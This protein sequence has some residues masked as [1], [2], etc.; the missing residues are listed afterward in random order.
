MAQAVLSYYPLPN[1]NLGVL[2]PSYNYQ[3][4]VPNPSNSN[5]F[6]IR[7]DQNINAKQQIYARGNPSNFGVLQAALPQGLGGN[8]T[9]QFSLRV[10][11]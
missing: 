4:L 6:D 10:D 1:A 3:T 2:N 5:G 11:F 8:R 7:L 9:G